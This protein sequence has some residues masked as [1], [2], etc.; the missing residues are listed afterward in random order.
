MSKGKRIV[1]MVA[2]CIAALAVILR[3]CG[4]EIRIRINPAYEGSSA[5]M[6]HAD[7]YEQSGGTGY[8]TILC[9]TLE[10]TRPIPIKVED[11]ELQDELASRGT[12]DVIGVQVGFSVPY[13]VWSQNHVQGKQYNIWD[14]IVATDAYDQY[15]VL[16]QVFFDE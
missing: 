11:A 15:L 5:V 3:V 14:E 13:K 7:R 8:L 9:D 10:P 2:V 4:V 16:T 1:L 6:C 12:E